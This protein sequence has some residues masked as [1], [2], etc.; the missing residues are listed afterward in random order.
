MSIFQAIFL[1]IIQGLTEFLPISSSGHLV[2]L[3][4]F[5]NWQLPQKEAFIFNILV[6]IGTLLAVLIYFRKD[7][8]DI[9]V[10][11]FKQLGKGTPFATSD[12]RM[13]WLLILATIPAGLAGLFL[14]DIVEGA[15]SSPLFAGIALLITGL[16]MIIAERVN[17]RIKDSY[18]ITLLDA[19]VMGLMQALALFPGISRSGATISGGMMRHIRREDAGNFSFLMSIPIMLAAGGLSIYEMLTEVTNLGE[20]LPIMGVGFVTAGVVGYLAIRWL[21]KF[22]KSHSLVYFSIYCF[23]LGATTILI[24]VLA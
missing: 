3:P 22:I 18:D 16:L 6:Q 10:A 8:R 11:F 20:F 1:G 4:Y 7:L 5:L 2:I 12:A 23:I 19:L 17:L 9:A 21:L 13:A 15:F 24:W 14:G